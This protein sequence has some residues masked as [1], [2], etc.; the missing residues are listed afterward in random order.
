MTKLDFQKR[1]AAKVLEVGESRV[2]LDPTK[3]EEIK[4]AVTK[5]DIRN[6]IKKGYIKALPPKI[7]K[8]KEKRKRRRGPGSKKGKKHSIVSKK[9][10]WIQTV[11][12]LRRYLKELLEKDKISKET[13]KKFYRLV[14]GGMFRSRSHLRIYLEQRG[15]IREKKK[16]KKKVKK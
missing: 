11:R 16:V 15:L 14:K 7:K 8:P 10:K 9:R 13:Y 12:P 2:W 4:K 3:M 6:L 1:L 5:A